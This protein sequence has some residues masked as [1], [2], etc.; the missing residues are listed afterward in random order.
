MPLLLTEAS[1]VLRL[2]NETVTEIEGGTFTEIEKDAYLL[3]ADSGYVRIRV[4][5][6]EPVKSLE[7]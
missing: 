1:F 4:A 7:E 2:N 6:S 5:P 3:R